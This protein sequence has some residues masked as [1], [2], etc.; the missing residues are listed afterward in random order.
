M[1]RKILYFVAATICVLFIGCPARSLS[2]LF[3][4]KDAVFSPTLVGM[5]K[6]IK[7][8]EVLTF[9]KSGEKSY[10]VIDREKNGDISTYKVQLGQLRKYW[11]VDLYSES[12][13]DRYDVLP[14]HLIWRIWI[15]NDTLRLASLEGDWLK[16]MIDTKRLDIPHALQDGDVI[17]TASTEELQQLVLRYADDDKAFPEQD[18]FVRM[19]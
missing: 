6:N 4:E 15:D 5:W 17:L 19:K 7:E 18:V 8:D 16:Q 13:K 14:V 1:L 10:D 2:P 12:C 9:L 11:F 3:D